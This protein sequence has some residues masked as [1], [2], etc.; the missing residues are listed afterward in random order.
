MIWNSF[1]RPCTKS[2][3]S[4]RT[5]PSMPNSLNS[6]A[7]Q[8]VPER[9]SQAKFKRDSVAF[10]NTGLPAANLVLCFRAISPLDQTCFACPPYRECFLITFLIFSR[11]RAGRRVA[12][13]CSWWAM[14][15]RS[16]KC[17][18]KCI[19]CPSCQGQRISAFRIAEKEWAT[20]RSGCNSKA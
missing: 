5:A 18:R 9:L 8:Q 20:S 17:I 16:L 7:V 11:I 19:R 14:A 13:N 6:D 2:N 12:F 3:S 4:S 10:C 15:A 1:S